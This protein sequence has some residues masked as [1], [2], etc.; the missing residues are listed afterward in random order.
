M[1]G[2]LLIHGAMHGGWCFDS[3]A[4]ILRA[5]GHTVWAPDL[6]GMGGSEEVLRSTT[7]ASWT[8]FALDQLRALR[9]EIGG[10]PLVLAGHSRGGLNI[11]A[12]AEADPTA[13]D[14]LV[15]ICALML[16]AGMSGDT[17]REVMPPEPELVELARTRSDTAAMIL[18]AELAVQ[19]FAQRSPPELARAAMV[20]L[21]AEPAGPLATPMAV[22]PERW[23]S[24]PRTYIE[25]LHDRTVSIANQRRMQELSPGSSVITLDSDHSPFLCAPE[26]LTEALEQAA[27]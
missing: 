19:V 27:R 4:G 10:A 24:V 25:C 1:A 8:D 9:R 12:A 13:M 17:M 20:R 15:Y 22:T 11:S 18:D 7:L 26:A 23:G 21:R 3:V 16:P 14:R 6:P 5:R 2:F